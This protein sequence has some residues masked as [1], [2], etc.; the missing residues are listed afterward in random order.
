MNK[1]PSYEVKA[2]CVDTSFDVASGNSAPNSPS[3]QQEESAN[4]ATNLDSFAK[5]GPLK[6]CDSMDDE[7]RCQESLAEETTQFDD[8]PNPQPRLFDAVPINGEVTPMPGEKDKGLKF[9]PKKQKYHEPSM[10][11]NPEEED[12]D[13]SRGVDN[14]DD[15]IG[16]SDEGEESLRS[17]TNK[18][19]ASPAQHNIFTFNPSPFKSRD[20]Q[21]DRNQPL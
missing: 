17:T 1:A 4:Q 9:A 5:A 8:V 16:G 21:D 12:S 3:S 18:K 13:D 20:Q 14:F 15:Y 6:L 7:L 10:R 11:P 19:E 2:P